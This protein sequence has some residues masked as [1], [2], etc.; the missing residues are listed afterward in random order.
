MPELVDGYRKLP[1]NL[2]RD[3][4]NGGLSP[5]KQLVEGLKVVDEEL[6]RMSETLASGDLN[7][8]ATQGRYLE[9]KYSGDGS[10]A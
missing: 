6:A 1:E 7:K 2:R 10:E 4:R 9:L 5:D 3:G 8:L